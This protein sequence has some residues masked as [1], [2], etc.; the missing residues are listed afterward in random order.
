MNNLSQ[1]LSCDWGTSSFRLRLVELPGLHVV[2]EVK[3]AEGNAATHE[4]WQQ[5]QQ[6]AEQRLAFYTAVLARHLQ[7]LEQRLGFPVNGELPVVIS[8]MASSTIGMQE[9]SYKELPFA[10]DGTDLAVQRLE[11]SPEFSHPILLVSGVKT[12]DDVMRGEE[13]Q[14]VGCQFEQI[15]EDQ[16]FL[17]PGTHAKHV[18][19]RD[20]Q[21]TALK[22]Y[23]TGELFSLLSTKSI[24][25]SAVEA[26]AQDELGQAGNRRSFEQGVHDGP[27]GN[28]LH[29]AFM[30]RTG[31]LFGQR[32]KTESY[33]YLS[34][35][36]IGT[37]LRDFPADFTGRIILAGEATLVTHY[38]AALE[39]LGIAGRAPVEVKGAEE[40][41]LRGQAQLLQR[42]F[43]KQADPQA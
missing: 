22:T 27:Q 23:M 3:S 20:G 34:G 16:L 19:V 32:T 26:P 15:A 8:G 17:H 40:V 28:L 2:G 6:P 11:P 13:T 4:A 38:Q 31:S 37:E 12:A 39:L 29:Q 25:A 43:A 35:L 7:Q 33:Y 36:L 42:A 18:T 41:T 24:L 21:A 1:F 14:L 30:V 10:A 5:A 9:L